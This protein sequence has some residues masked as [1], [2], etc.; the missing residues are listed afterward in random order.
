MFGASNVRAPCE[1]VK[2]NGRNTEQRSPAMRT[3]A[4]HTPLKQSHRKRR[5]SM[6]NERLIW[7]STLSCCF[8]FIGIILVKFFFV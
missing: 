4:G 8:L 2:I 1:K 5:C 3:D 7:N 6:Y